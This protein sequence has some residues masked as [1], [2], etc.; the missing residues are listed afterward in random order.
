[1]NQ[2]PN[3]IAAEKNVPVERSGKAPESMQVKPNQDYTLSPAVTEGLPLQA[4]ATGAEGQEM[5][6]VLAV[7]DNIPGHL[8][9]E[10]ETSLRNGTRSA[11]ATPAAAPAKL[12]MPIAGAEANRN[13][14]V[15]TDTERIPEHLAQEGDTRLRL[16]GAVAPYE[17]PSMALK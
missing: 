8:E 11:Q 6:P 3:D 5:V 9:Q 17:M 16:A 13:R 12:A 1:M 14:S 2:K 4:A 10:D 7:T 15:F